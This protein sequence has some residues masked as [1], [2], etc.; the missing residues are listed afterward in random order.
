MIQNPMTNLNILN[1]LIKNQNFEKKENFGKQNNGKYI[2]KKINFYINQGIIEFN[3]KG[4]ANKT[5][6]NLS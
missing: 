6:L 4:K 2:K 5:I 1:L 3:E